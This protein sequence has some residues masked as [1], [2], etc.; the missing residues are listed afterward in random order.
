MYDHILSLIQKHQYYFVLIIIINIESQKRRKFVSSFSIRKF[1]LLAAVELPKKVVLYFRFA[2]TITS[3]NY[4]FKYFIL[5]GIT[6]AGIIIF[7]TFLG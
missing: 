2:Q 6:H 3:T 5:K 7:E 1:L 4:I